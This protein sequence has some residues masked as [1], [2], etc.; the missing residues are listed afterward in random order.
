MS[1]FMSFSV[2]GLCLIFSTLFGSVIFNYGCFILFCLDMVWLAPLGA[3]WVVKGKVVAS[4]GSRPCATIGR[5]LILHVS[6][7]VLNHGHY[8]LNQ[9]LSRSCA[10]CLNSCSCMFNINV[11]RFVKS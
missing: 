11:A 8:K 4:L 10:R 9:V 3:Y 2:G 5:R 6:P 7:F 1:Y